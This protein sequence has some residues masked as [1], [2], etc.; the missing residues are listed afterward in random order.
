MIAGAKINLVNAQNDLKAAKAAK[1]G[2]DAFF[3]NQLTAFYTAYAAWSAKLTC[4]PPPPASPPPASPP[5]ESPPPESPP[6]TPPSSP[7]TPDDPPSPDDSPP[8]P[9]GGADNDPELRGFDGSRC[10]AAAAAAHRAATRALSCVHPPSSPPPHPH[11]TARFH[12][13]DLGDFVLVE[14]S[15]GWRVEATFAPADTPNPDTGRDASFTSAVRVWAPTGEAQVH[16]G[17]CIMLRCMRSTQ[18]C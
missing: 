6:L 15:D 5:P 13:N 10:A 3:Q 17:V 11:H 9:D 7:P 2:A 12:F 1:D 14:E 16:A 4:S 18:A 8:A